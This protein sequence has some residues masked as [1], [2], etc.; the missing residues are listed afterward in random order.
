MRRKARSREGLLGVLAVAAAACSVETDAPGTFGEEGTAPGETSGDGSGGDDGSSDTWPGDTDGTDGGPGTG[1]EAPPWLIHTSESQLWHVDIATGEATAVC[2]LVP[3][4]DG[5]TVP[6]GFTSVT[7]SRDDRL[8]G[9]SGAALW[10]I[11]LPTCITRKIGDYAAT[12]LKIWGFCPD[13]GND[14]YGIAVET[15]TL[16][17]IDVTTGVATEIGPVGVD[18]FLS[19]ATWLDDTQ[20]VLG[21]LGT[22]GADG[23]FEFDTATG[24][25]TRTI[26]LNREFTKVGMEHHPRNGVIYACMDPDGDPAWDSAPLLRVDRDTGNVELIGLTGLSGC[27]NLGGPWGDPPLPNPP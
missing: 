8:L 2:D 14:L 21:I 27:T 25:G 23:L 7:F 24:A 11:E 26:D 3:E 20:E 6:A 9:S 1:G 17:H 13:E 16:Q 5:G 19:G 12:D 22:T 15:D 10:E 4:E 18:F